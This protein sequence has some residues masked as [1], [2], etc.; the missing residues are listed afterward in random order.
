MNATAAVIA[1]VRTDDRCLV[2]VSADGG[3]TLVADLSGYTSPPIND[4]VIDLDGASSAAAE[5]LLLPNGMVFL[6]RGRTLVVAESLGARLTGYTVAAG[7]SLTNRRLWAQMPGDLLPERICA[8]ADGAIWVASATVTECV[9]VVEGGDV[10]DWVRTGGAAAIAC[11]LGGP[12]GRTLL[13][14]TDGRILA[15]EVTI[16]AER[17]DERTRTNV[18]RSCVLRLHRSL[19]RRSRGWVGHRLLGVPTLLMTTTGRRTGQPRTNAL[20]YMTVGDDLAVVASNGGRDT[21]PAWLL[22]LAAKPHVGVQVG[23]HRSS[24]T[25]QVVTP[26]DARYDDL[27]ASC[28]AANRNRYSAYQ[29]Q[30]DRPIPVVLLTPTEATD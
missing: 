29:R 5:D 12:E 30:T 17:A 6:D 26:D 24:A 3:V 7:G 18:S 20:T 10:V 23:R 19:Y 2:R 27:F 11:T 1:D 9:R 15:A 14:A 22:N 25:A 4:L 28:D 13:I 16:E 21:P 8:D